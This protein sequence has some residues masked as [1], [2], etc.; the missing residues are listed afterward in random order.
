MITDKYQNLMCWFIIITVKPVLS[1][2]S[3]EEK[4]RFSRPIIT[5]CR[6]IVLQNAPVEHSAVLLTCI[7]L[8]HGFKTFV[9]S[10]FELLLKTVF[11]VHTLI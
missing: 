11:T 9:P 2:Y 1:G 10:I 6:S 8:S 5:K 3:K 4:K 7:K